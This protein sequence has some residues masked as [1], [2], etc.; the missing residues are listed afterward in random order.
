[1]TCVGE[2]DVSKD[3]DRRSAHHGGGRGVGL[4]HA[5]LAEEVGLAQSAPVPP[6][7]RHVDQA[8]QDHDDHVVA[9]P[10][11]IITVPAGMLT[12]S[13]WLARNSRSA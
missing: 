9:P 12:S 8:F 10:S 5:D 2:L 4:D 6:V 13:N 1:M 3:P 11:V 7:H